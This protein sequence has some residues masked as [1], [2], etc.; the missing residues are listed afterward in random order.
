MRSSVYLSEVFGFTGLDE[1]KRDAGKE[2]ELIKELDFVNGFL[3][4][5]GRLR[6]GLAAK[7]EGSVELLGGCWLG[8]RFYMTRAQSLKFGSQGA[9]AAQTEKRTDERRH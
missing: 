8:D 7:W 6:R 1:R 2:E 3:E 9:C 4:A 5:A